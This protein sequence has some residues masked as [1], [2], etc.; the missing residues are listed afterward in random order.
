MVI[1]GARLVAVGI[2]MLALCA[3]G[4]DDQP[5][6]P[7][8]T[9]PVATTPPPTTTSPTTTPT[10]PPPV[11]G[12][13]VDFQTARPIPGA[14]VGFAAGIGL[15]GTLTG[16]AQTSV[17]DA[18]GEYSLPEPP[19]LPF[20]ATYLLAV[21]SRSVGR[22]Y[23]RGANKRAG[24]LAVHTAGQC[25]TRY[26]MVLDRSTFLPIVGARV[27]NLSNQVIATTD[28]DGWWQFD[29]GCSTGSVGFNTTW[30]IADHPDYNSESFSGGRGFQGVV[31]DD[32]LLTFRRR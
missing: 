28:R 8:T 22:G 32:V 5:T 2:V 31:R 21:N 25:V 7:T 16:I 3:C 6:A 20:Q 1:M 13:V 4:H 18:N 12:R 19:L 14:V 9:P 27:R 26:G 24:D 17:T 23:P 10:P 30:L 29:W 15:G 11:R